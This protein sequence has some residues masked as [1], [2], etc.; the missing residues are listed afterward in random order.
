MVSVVE[1]VKKAWNFMWH[2]DS[3]LAQLLSLLFIFVILKFLFFPMVGFLLHTKFPIVAIVSGS[4][5]HKVVGGVICGKY[6]GGKDGAVDF[7]TFWDICGDYYENLG[8]GKSQFESFSFS[9]GLNIGDVMIVYGKKSEDINVGDVIVF[10]PLNE[11]FYV[12]KGPVIHRVV[13]KWQDNGKFYFMTKGDHNGGSGVGFEDQ[14]PEDNV[15]GVAVVRIPYLG[16]PKYWLVRLIG[17]FI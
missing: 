3:L 7:N 10:K 14:I 17:N 2:D 16:L 13:K 1:L 6:V 9:D 5:E 8:I 15:F 4:M 11:E 12:K